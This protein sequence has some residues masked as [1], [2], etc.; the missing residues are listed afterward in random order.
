MIGL[1]AW[2]HP[3]PDNKMHRPFIRLEETEDIEE[4]NTFNRIGWRDKPLSYLT[5]FVNKWDWTWLITDGPYTFINA[6]IYLLATRLGKE[7]IFYTTN[8]FWEE[9]LNKKPSGRKYWKEYLGHD[10]TT[11]VATEVAAKSIRGAT[12]VITDHI[13]PPSC[14]TEVFYS[15]EVKERDRPLVLFVGRLVP[16]KNIDFILELAR[17]NPEYDFWIRGDGELRD[18]V[19]ESVKELD[20][21]SLKGRVEKSRLAEYY[22]EADILIHPALRRGRRTE[23]FGVVI[24]EALACETPVLAY[25]TAGPESILKDIGV[26]VEQGDEKVFEEKL[27]ELLEDEERREKLGRKG[28]ELVKE[29]YDV[30]VIA[31]KWLNILEEQEVSD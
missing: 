17:R 3:K 20:N 1:Q 24:I 2:W 23:L 21:L 26:L 6:M 31:E 5:E 27:V 30:D 28:R 25:D 9:W 8:V 4:Y 13:I 12:G 14:D 29:E 10:R 15:R 7:T 18:T 22:S 19:L 16:Y 11:V